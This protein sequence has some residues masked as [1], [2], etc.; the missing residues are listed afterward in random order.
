MAA[1][2][3]PVIRMLEAKALCSPC[4]VPPIRM[5]FSS[6]HAPLRRRRAKCWNLDHSHGL[7]GEKI[8]PKFD[9]RDFSKYFGNFQ[10]FSKKGIYTL[11]GG[12]STHSL[13][14][15]KSHSPSLDP[16]S[17]RTSPFPAYSEW[18][19]QFPSS[20]PGLEERKDA[21]S[22]VYFRSPA[23][24][25]LTSSLTTAKLYVYVFCLCNVAWKPRKRGV[26]HNSPDVRGQ[27]ASML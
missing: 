23:H 17:P 11:L 3:F 25:R 4:S 10:D 1:V 2:N 19:T 26:T 14:C 12:S 27:P 20:R 18:P 8:S 22:N 7:I 15:E 13:R 21:K 5:A 16:S 24:S 6:S 9:Y